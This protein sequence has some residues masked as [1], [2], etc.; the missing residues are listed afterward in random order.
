MI[1]CNISN[2]MTIPE[3]FLD[4]FQELSVFVSHQVVLISAGDLN[5]IYKIMKYNLNAL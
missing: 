3:P 1:I 5:A 4:I 2:E